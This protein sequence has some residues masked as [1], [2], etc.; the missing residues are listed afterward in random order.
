MHIPFKKTRDGFETQMAVNYF[1]HA[2]LTHLLIP[3]LTAGA[4]ELNKNSRIVN[5]SSCAQKSGQLDYNDM[6]MEKYYHPGIQYGNS[7]LAQVL[8]SNHVDKICNS[9]NLKIQSHCVHPGVVDTDIFNSVPLFK[10]MSYIRRLVM[11]VSL[12]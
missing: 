4:K 12:S 7:K 9:K 3:Q 5:V 2:L 10:Y 6:N 8:F 1:G 11:K